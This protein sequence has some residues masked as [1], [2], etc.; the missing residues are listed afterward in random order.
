[1]FPRAL[2]AAMKIGARLRLEGFHVS[3][4]GPD[5]SLFE[6]T[7][8]GGAAS[9]IRFNVVHAREDVVNTTAHGLA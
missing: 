8:R 5:G 2:Q 7:D 9:P 6:A 3:I 4:T 1:V